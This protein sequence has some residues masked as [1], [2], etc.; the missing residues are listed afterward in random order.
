MKP[1]SRCRTN[2]CVLVSVIFL[3]AACFAAAADHAVILQ[4]HHF[5][6]DTPS[7]TSVTLEQFD[8]HLAYLNKNKF[9]VWPLNRIVS[10]L[11]GK[12][13]LPE[14]CVAI[15]IDDAYRSVYEKAFPRLQKYGWPF[16]VFVTTQ[17][18]DKG[19][20]D[21]MTWEQMREMTKKGVTFA[22][23]SHTHSYLRLH[24]NGESKTKWQERVTRDILA[25]FE[26]IKAETGQDSRL[27]AYPY[28]EY[29]N[30]LKKIILG[31]EL[32]GLG[33]QSGPVWSGSDFGA[34]PRFP[35]S[36]GY[37][38]IDEFKTKV[39]SRPLPVVC[40]APDDPELPDNMD[41]PVLRLTLSQGD[42]LKETLTCYLSG[43]G[44]IR[45]KWI[46]R[47]RGI[48]EAVSDMPLPKGRS[49]Y[50]FTARHKSRPGYF[51][52]SHLWIRD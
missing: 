48:V 39:N 24:N 30:E 22:G 11:L 23:H 14:K 20:A 3:Y 21:Y 38:Q 49:R 27:F 45:L 43:Q 29:N 17:G 52:H 36:A 12:K 32:I 46:D 16:T 13:G 2:S 47:N 15:T 41:K 50:N 51:W 4:Y 1:C 7:S 10:H 31:H 44:P 35:M 40:S 33:Q 5:G 25:S 18:V 6:N 28:G 19:F 37:A 9:V 42:Y 34:L 8:T 26:R